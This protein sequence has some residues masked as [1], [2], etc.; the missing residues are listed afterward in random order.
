[1]NLVK[2]KSRDGWSP[3]IRN[4][5]AKYGDLKITTI[6][7]MRVPVQSMITKALNWV[8]NGTFNNNVKAAGYDT[9][10]HLFLVVGL[11]DNT[12][13]KMEK[14]HVPEFKLVDPNIPNAE[15][16]PV[17]SSGNTLNDF[18]EKGVASVGTS[19]FFTYDSGSD[20]CQAFVMALLSSN[21]IL[22]NELN[23]CILQDATQ[24][25]KGLGLLQKVN[26][27]ITDGAAVLDHAIAG[28]GRKK[29]QTNK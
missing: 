15:K 13:I 28:A 27:V 21:S 6:Q 19:K 5:L 26:K 16:M 12:S 10:F 23:T 8:T 9:L 25:Y 7:V 22:T 17:R 4:I 3:N 20:N 1:M 14:N 18:L 11:S 2:G 24:I 29:R